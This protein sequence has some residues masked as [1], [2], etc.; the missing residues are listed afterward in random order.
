MSVTV[1][2]TGASGLLGR[3]LCRELKNNAASW[4]VH[5]LAWSR[6]TGDLL[7]VDITNRSSVREVFQRL[8]VSSRVNVA[9]QFGKNCKD[10]V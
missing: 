8:E 4:V 2:V 6:A 5:G 1:I 7:K 3:A 10:S 9:V